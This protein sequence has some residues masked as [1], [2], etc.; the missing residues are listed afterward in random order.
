MQTLFFCINYI[1]ITHGISSCLCKTFQTST[2]FFAPA[3]WLP[4]NPLLIC[5][6]SPANSRAR[7]LRAMGGNL[8]KALAVLQKKPTEP[9]EAPLEDPPTP[10]APDPRMPL[11]ARQLFNISKSWKGIARAMEPTGITM[12]VR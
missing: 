1:N 7:E 2:V 4:I 9:P 10:P 8:S 6:T 11:T 12:F 3:Q 5:I